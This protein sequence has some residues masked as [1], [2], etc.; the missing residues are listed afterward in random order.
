[1]FMRTDFRKKKEWENK[2]GRNRIVWYARKSVIRTMAR[3]IISTLITFSK[4]N[5]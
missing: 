1:M 4:Q 3:S 2:K 5:D